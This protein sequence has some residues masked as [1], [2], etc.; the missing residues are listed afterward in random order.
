MI[1]WVDP[2][3]TRFKLWPRPQMFR[4]H[5][6]EEGSPEAVPF[7]QR[8]AERVAALVGSWPFL[9]IQA[10][11]L[12][13]WLIYNTL[14][15]T[16]H[17]DPPPYILLNLLLSFQAAFTG[18]VLLIAA[19]VGAMRDHKQYDRIERLTAK[20][21]DIGEST[22]ELANRLVDVERQLDVHVSQS[23]QAHTAELRELS[24][25]VRAMHAIVVTSYGFTAAAADASSSAPDPPEA[26]AES[27]LNRPTTGATPQAA[28][29]GAPAPRR[30]SPRAGKRH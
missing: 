21:E 30:A 5:V 8:L 29:A 3:I 10:M 25:L 17:F 4:V 26:V 19:N 27:S 16:N 1:K 7:G 13:L 23:L 11:F 20:T 28:S 22:R 6:H 15:I 24:D 12:V 18:P 2:I 14:Q 9:I